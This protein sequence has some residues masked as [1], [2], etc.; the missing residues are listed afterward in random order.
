MAPVNDENSWT[1]IIREIFDG[2]P[3]LTNGIKDIILA[4][5]VLYGAY[6]TA[7]ASSKLDTQGVKLDDAATKAEVA[8]TKADI[9][10][11]KVDTVKTTLDTN[12]EERKE[13]FDHIQKTLNA[14]VSRDIEDMNAA[15]APEG[16]A[17]AA[18]PNPS[19]Q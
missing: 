13:Q 4:L 18:R 15:K 12:K 14:V 7:S 17:S 8:A 11:I 16:K 1:S 9:A 5:G 6:A 19:P 2:I 3:K 10:A